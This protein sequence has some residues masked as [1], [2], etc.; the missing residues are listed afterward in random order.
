MLRSK[1]KFI[2]VSGNAND[3]KNLH[4]RG[5]KFVFFIDFPFLIY[6]LF[7]LRF[8]CFF[9]Y[10]FFNCLFEVFGNYGGWMVKQFS[11]DWFQ[12]FVFIGPTDEGGGEPT[13]QTLLN[14]SYNGEALYKY[15]L[16]KKD[17]KLHK[18]CDTPWHVT[19]L[20][21]SWHYQFFN[22]FKDIKKWGSTGVDCILL[23]NF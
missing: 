6:Y 14:L 19:H 18:L 1:K 17:R 3:E 8:F 12:G 2:L 16:P 10:F 13:S 9:D 20:D 5:R 11:S 15:T 7:F 22:G 23:F 21:F 4:P